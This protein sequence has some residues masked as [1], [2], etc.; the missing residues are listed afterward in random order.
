ME[1]NA[2][3]YEVA[4]KVGYKNVPYFSTVFKKFTGMNPTELVK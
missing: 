4:E 3:V 1:K 2:L